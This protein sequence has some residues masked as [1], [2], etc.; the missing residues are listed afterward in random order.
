MHLSRSMLQIHFQMSAVRSGT[1]A[2]DGDFTSFL[3]E[4]YLIHNVVLFSDVQQ[5]N[6]FKN[7]YIY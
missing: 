5:C 6:S 7:I 4:V 2:E 1:D 3:I